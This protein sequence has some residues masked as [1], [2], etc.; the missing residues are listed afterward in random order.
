MGWVMRFTF[1]KCPA[2][3]SNYSTLPTLLLVQDG[4]Q[5]YGTGIHMHLEWFCKISKGQN[6]GRDAHY[7]QCI[8]GFL[9]F[10]HPLNFL[11]LMGSILP[12]DLVIEEAGNLGIPFFETSVV[13]HEA[14][15]TL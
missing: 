2:N 12:K 7:L 8:K 10:L 15:E 3:I 1:G 4:T 14:Q 9:A 6:W 11:F 5:P 13:A